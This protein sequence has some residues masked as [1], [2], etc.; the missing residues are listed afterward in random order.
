MSAGYQ[1][2]QMCHSSACEVVKVG[3]REPYNFPVT[4]G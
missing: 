1:A 3:D 2:Q 4:W